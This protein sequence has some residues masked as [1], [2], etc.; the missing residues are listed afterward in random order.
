MAG[1]AP[2]GARPG[3]VRDVL[4]PHTLS[5]L[6]GPLVGSVGLPARMFWS[7]PDPRAVRWDLA[8][9]ERRRDFYEI[10]LA[11]GSLDDVCALVDGPE[12]ARLWDRMYL[13]PWVRAAWQPLIDAARRA[14]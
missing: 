12:L 11:E 14:A 1:V 8:D 10:V 9:P 3:W 2:S 5:E 4:V 6:R 7:G 13:P